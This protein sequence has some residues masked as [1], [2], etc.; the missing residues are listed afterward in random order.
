MGFAAQDLEQVVGALDAAVGGPPGAVPVE[1]L[2]VPGQERVGD[3]AEL[4]YLAGAVDVGE[5]VQG[6]ESA[7]SVLGEI[8]A[9]Q[10][11]ERFPRELEPRVR[12]HRAATSR[13]R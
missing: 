5:P 4:G 3:V 10:L 1:D 8:E 11:A 9:V 2:F 12:L 6:G 7:F 13:S